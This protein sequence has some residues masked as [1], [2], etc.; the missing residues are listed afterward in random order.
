VNRR[1]LFRLALASPAAFL[2]E[3]YGVPGPK[4]GNVTWIETRVVVPGPEEQT[5][6]WLLAKRPGDLTPAR[7]TAEMLELLDEWVRKGWLAPD[8]RQHLPDVEVVVRL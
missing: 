4:R 3:K 6:R 7:A 2:V 8:W 1:D 5:A